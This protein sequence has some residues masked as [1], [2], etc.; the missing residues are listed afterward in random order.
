MCR[1]S[2]PRKGKKT[3]NKNKTKQKKHKYLFGKY[4]LSLKT[5]ENMSSEKLV[6]ELLNSHLSLIKN[7]TQFYHLNYFYYLPQSDTYLYF[8]KLI[9]LRS[10]GPILKN[11]SKAK[12]TISEGD[13][14][15]YDTLVYSKFPEGTP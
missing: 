15:H 8:S 5:L 4:I 13:S 11:K 14:F 10:K 2:G 1:G 9:Y 7:I 3:K 12:K 6:H